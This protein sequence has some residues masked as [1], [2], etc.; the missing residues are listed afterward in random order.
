MML[1]LMLHVFVIVRDIENDLDRR[2]QL[3]RKSRDRIH[4]ITLQMWIGRTAILAVEA[5]VFE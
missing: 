2:V 5:F 4:D 1:L 3:V